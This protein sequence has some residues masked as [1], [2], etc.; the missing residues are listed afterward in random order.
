MTQ[1]EANRSQTESYLSGIGGT[2]SLSGTIGRRK[3]VHNRH[4]PRSPTILAIMLARVILCLVL[5]T[6][7]HYTCAE[8]AW[9]STTRDGY[10]HK[11]YGHPK[12]W[13]LVGVGD[14]MGLGSRG[15]A[16]EYCLRG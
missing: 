1:R 15:D 8:D 6:V 12:W 11:F 10:M 7:F 14:S 16:I 5:N 9:K 3:D 13:F 2:S 4:L